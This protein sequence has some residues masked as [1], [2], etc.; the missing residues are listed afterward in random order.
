MWY[1]YIYIRRIYNTYLEVKQVR[2]VLQSILALN[3]LPESWFWFWRFWSEI[4]F[5][6]LPEI[7]GKFWTWIRLD[8]TPFFSPLALAVATLPSVGKF[9]RKTWQFSLKQSPLKFAHHSHSTAELAHKAPWLWSAQRWESHDQDGILPRSLLVQHR[10]VWHVRDGTARSF[11]TTCRVPNEHFSA[12]WPL[13]RWV[14]GHDIP[15]TA[16]GNKDSAPTFA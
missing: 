5:S 11:T 2:L 14:K 16:T 7:L 12:I 9:A 8:E 10:R 1:I 13:A 15:V 6:K 3:V 4:L